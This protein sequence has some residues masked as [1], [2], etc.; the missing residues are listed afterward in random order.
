MD[1]DEGPSIPKPS[2]DL[3][4]AVRTAN[5][6]VKNVRCQIF[7]PVQRHERVHVRLFPSQSQLK[8][9]E[10]NW[11]VAISGYVRDVGGGSTSRI[12]VPALYCHSFR[13]KSGPGR[14][15]ENLI[16][17][18]VKRLEIRHLFGLRKGEPKKQR[19]TQQEVWYWLT[20]LDL[21][22]PSQGIWRHDTGSVRVT[23]VWKLSL[24]IAGSKASFQTVY[25]TNEDNRETTVFQE[26]VL[27]V[28]AG[29]RGEVP[30]FENIEDLLLLASFASR[31]RC[32]C[33][34]WTASRPDGDP[35]EVYRQDISVPEE[36][37][38]RSRRESII[39]KGQIQGFLRTSLRTLAKSEGKEDLRSA[40]WG[41]IPNYK[42]TMDVS[43][44]KLF[45]ALETLVL[46]ERRR[47]G[48]DV[49]LDDIAWTETQKAIRKTVKS[50]VPD[51]RS[52]SLLY[53]NLSGLNRVSFRVAF[54]EFRKELAVDLSDLWPLVDTT[55]GPSLVS[56][57]NRIAHG[58]A[59]SFAGGY[60]FLV[61]LLHL[62]WVAERLTLGV[63]G[64]EVNASTISAQALQMQS[65]HR[66]LSTARDGIARLMRRRESAG[67]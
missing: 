19:L 9:L 15:T 67:A 12:S 40:L 53:E 49:I 24:K 52:R 26:L 46:Q 44:M 63:L 41:V 5:T 61:A 14:F 57:R 7:L 33:V 22:T 11:E 31:E 30:S 32:A 50:L 2:Y 62:G 27:H 66:D 54:E 55:G 59:A 65:A 64:W 34:G 21:A 10:H 42:Q 6:T 36:R 39:D 45:S 37:A 16:E 60:E 23:T 51:G 4:V 25:R 1:A 20:P 56:I 48:V 8:R 58:D 38:P 29:A 13:N 47:S 43:F 18:T 28:K 35:V 3:F 17:A